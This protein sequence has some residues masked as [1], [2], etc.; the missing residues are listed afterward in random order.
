MAGASAEVSRVSVRVLPDLTGFRDKLRTD[1]ERATRG[2]TADIRARVDSTGLRD[3]LQAAANAASAGVRAQIGVSVDRSA[4]SRLTQGLKTGPIKALTGLFG[5]LSKSVAG[6]AGAGGAVQVIAGV[7]A[8]LQQLSGIALLAPAAIGALT[9]SIVALKLGMQGFSD[10]VR[11]GDLSK[12]SA[13]AREAAT[14]L[15][16]FR[17]EWAGVQQATQDALF[18]D[19]AGPIRQLGQTYLPLLR[20]QLPGIA[21][22]FRDMAASMLETLS[23]SRQVGNVRSILEGTRGAIANASDSLGNLTAGFLN[24]GGAGAKYLPAIGTWLNDITARFDAW[25]QS[26]VDSG[27]FD[28]L[29]QNAKAAFGDLFATIGN[30]G[31]ALGSAFSA[32][33]EGMSGASPLAN[34]RELSQVLADTLASPAFQEAFRALGA[35]M[36]VAGQA[37]RE[38]IGALLQALAP[39]LTAIM[40]LIQ[41][42]AKAL[43]SALVPA[44]QVLG[45]PIT[46]LV[47]ALV[48]ALVPILPILAQM[49]AALA[50]AV[51]P[52]VEAL[53]PLVQQIGE[54]LAPVLAR[55]APIIG[56]IALQLGTVLGDAI[57]ALSP[58]LPPLV[59]AIGAILEAVLPILQPLL[60]LAGLILPMLADIITT[61]VV[62][63]LEFIAWVVSNV[64]APVIQF[65]ADAI[66]TAVEGVSAAISWI[67]DR[68]SEGVAWI[69]D[70]GGEI[71]SWFTGLPGKIL[72][73][74]GNLG[75]L[76]LDSGGALVDGFLNGIKGAW[77]GLVGWVQKGMEWLRSLWPFSPAKTGPFSG[78]GYV[79]YSGKA[80]TG[81][82]AKAI[83]A[84]IPTV[85]GAADDLMSATQGQL[86]GIDAL[87]VDANWRAA[88]DNT[89][90]DPEY[91]DQ[92]VEN[93]VTV[94][95]DGNVLARSVN[96]TNTR[97]AWR[98]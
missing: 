35:T 62:P 6:L 85:I 43:S 23:S 37:F 57:T 61:V 78:T 74:I 65:L 89:T 44:L 49:F 83:R 9:A 19:M 77:N 20:Q 66:S 12:L 52:I 80:L 64:V 73:A 8:A 71:L 18:R 40:P 84:G 81:D 38:I 72:G 70:K 42:F 51:A 41:A 50:K 31:S 55:L 87:S 14:A 94:D 10:A 96:R 75:S 68:I 98:R 58:I 60:D 92:V 22:G 93:H 5:I 95:L 79:T 16:G 21:G 34:L 27:R 47:E 7:A 91:G 33:S 86:A 30:V 39:I 45:P 28:V 88:L 36:Q 1:L 63:A 53:A 24:L 69:V 4:L 32:I 48:G 67:G 97:K 26:L 25:S 17:Q 46:A 3:E 15:R 29:V 59:E 11:S 13:Q 76:L 56:D 54:V 82:F 90:Q 2:L